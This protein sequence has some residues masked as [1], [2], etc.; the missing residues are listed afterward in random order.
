MVSRPARV[1]GSAKKKQHPV[2]ALIKR[3]LSFFRPSIRTDY[4]PAKDVNNGEYFKSNCRRNE[5]F[6][7]VKNTGTPLARIKLAHERGRCSDGIA[8]CV[9]PKIAATSSAKS[10]LS[11]DGFCE[12]G[13]KFGRGISARKISVRNRN[14]ELCYLVETFIH[15][16]T[17]GN[18]FNVVRATEAVTD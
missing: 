8:L 16:R 1:I 2:D 5:R 6:R 17:A 4:A 18:E 10:V 3:Q 15:G 7:P 14:A 12:R 9:V 11:G 13:S